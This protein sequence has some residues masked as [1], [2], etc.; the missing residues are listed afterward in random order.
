MGVHSYATEHGVR[1]RIA[2]KQPD[3]RLTTRRGF[4]THEA[5]ARASESRHGDRTHIVGRSESARLRYP[6]AVNH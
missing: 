1:W 2:I 5:A 4:R 3:G 6:S